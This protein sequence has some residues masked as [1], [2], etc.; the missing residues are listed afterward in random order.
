MKRSL[1]SRHRI[2]QALRR[3]GFEIHRTRSPSTRSGREDIVE[4]PPLGPIWPL[5]RSA[6]GPSD[7]EI[8]SGFEKHATLLY[9]YEFEGG[10][11]FWEAHERLGPRL[12]G[13]P[14]YFAK[15]FRHFMPYV[16]AAQGGSLKG[17]RV[18]DIAC[19]SGYWSIQCAL[20][21]AE[22]VAFETRPEQIELANLVKAAAGLQNV[23]FSVLDF[24]DMSPETLGGTFDVVLNLGILYHLSRP[25]EALERTL[26]MA[27]THVLL[28]T[29]VY[30]AEGPLIKLQWDRSEDIRMAVD[31]GVAALPSKEAIEMMLKHVRAKDWFEVPVRDK[32]SPDRYLNHEQ[33][34]WLITA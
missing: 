25:V 30:P 24:W 21:G 11:R 1:F 14:H 16:V 19:S 31:E 34:S 8:R 22:V 20:L 29:A 33:A 18:L 3:L 15:R 17:K 32:V 5:P 9:P 4:P 7:D 28:D 27:K 26:A 2:N 13:D 10:M 23:E 12:A 6:E